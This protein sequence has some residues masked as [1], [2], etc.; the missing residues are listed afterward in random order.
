MMWRVLCHNPRTWQD[1]EQ[2]V[3]ADEMI[4]NGGVLVFLTDQKI[5]RII[6][7]FRECTPVPNLSQPTTYVE[8]PDCTDPSPPSL[9]GV[10]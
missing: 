6:R 3:T 10:L 2:T 1:Q 8:P 4:V 7:D 9:G 5:S